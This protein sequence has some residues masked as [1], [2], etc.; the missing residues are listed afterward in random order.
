VGGEA[1][2]LPRRWYSQQMKIAERMYPAMKS[3]RKTSWSLGWRAVSKMERRI[4]PTVP[5]MANTMVRAERA[6]SPVVALGTSRPRCRSQRSER[7]EMSRKTVVMT[8]PAMKSGLR[9][10]APTSLM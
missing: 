6:F 2:R 9:L 3:R 7:K 1:L 8:Q 10:E 5:R 4:R